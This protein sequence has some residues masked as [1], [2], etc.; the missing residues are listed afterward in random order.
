MTVYWPMA[1]VKESNEIMY[2]DGYR[3]QSTYDSCFNIRDSI[4]AIN[5]WK[6]HYHFDIID[7]WIQVVEDGVH[8]HDILVGYAPLSAIP[9]RKED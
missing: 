7:S 2:P 8:T 3:L 4:Q 9:I 1:K 5:T 6:E